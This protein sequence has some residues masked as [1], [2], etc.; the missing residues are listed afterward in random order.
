[1]NTIYCWNTNIQYIEYMYLHIC[2]HIYIPGLSYILGTGETIN[3]KSN[4]LVNIEFIRLFRCLFEW[5]WVKWTYVNIWNLIWNL[6]INE[7]LFWNLLCAVIAFKSELLTIKTI[8][9]LPWNEIEEF[10][11]MTLG[12]TVHHL[13]NNTQKKTV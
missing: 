1:M 12:K 7:T 13:N 9:F 11:N 5:T 8:I 2:I 6:P 10:L 4:S 3:I